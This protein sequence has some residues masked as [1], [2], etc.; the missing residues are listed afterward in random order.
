[1]ALLTRYRTGLTQQANPE[2]G[3]GRQQAHSGALRRSQRLLSL[4][5]K[6]Q[7]TPP[8]HKRDNGNPLDKPHR[9]VMIVAPTASPHK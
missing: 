9:V 1:M 5:G 8:S 7:S 3:D 4:T 2:H 6:W